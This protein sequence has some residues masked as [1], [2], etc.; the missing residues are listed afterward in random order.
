M[1]VKCDK[2]GRELLHNVY[3]GFYAR[4]KTW[5]RLCYSCLCELFAQEDD[6]KEASPCQSAEGA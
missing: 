5:D 2:C 6:H 3:V 1:P 4:G